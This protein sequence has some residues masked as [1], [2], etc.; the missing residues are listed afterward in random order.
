MRL[1]LVSPQGWSGALKWNLGGPRPCPASAQVRFKYPDPN[2]QSLSLMRR[3]AQGYKIIREEREDKRAKVLLTPHKPHFIIIFVPVTSQLWMSLKQ[4]VFPRFPWWAVRNDFADPRE[5]DKLREEW[6][7]GA[8]DQRPGLPR[9]QE[10][11]PGRFLNFC[12]TAF[13]QWLG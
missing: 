10:Y 8:S 7:G 11:Y 4:S 5:L 12:T 1:E 2:F 3:F 13:C 6:P 9:L